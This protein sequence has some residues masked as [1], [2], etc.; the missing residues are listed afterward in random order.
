MTRTSPRGWA[1]LLLN[2]VQYSSV[3]LSSF[4]FGLF[5]PFIRADL[6]LTYLQVGILQGVWW[7]ASALFLLP[8]S[9]LLGRI[10]P[11]RRVLAALALL[12]P[13]LCAQGLAGGFGALL[14]A[15]FLTVVTYAAMA[16]AP[17]SCAAGPPPPS[18]P[19]S[20]RPD[21]PSTRRQWRRR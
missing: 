7:A 12:T 8:F 20:P 1:V 21:C 3:V 9:V 2:R 17:C 14:T 18:I 11:D 4:A 13:F 6:G 5:L 19:P 10:N 15:R 16:P